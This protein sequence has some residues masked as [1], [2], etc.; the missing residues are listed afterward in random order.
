M[1]F[2]P[3]FL[4]SC[5][6]AAEKMLHESRHFLLAQFAEANRVREKDRDYAGSKTIFRSGSAGCRRARE[7]RL[8][9]VFSFGKI[10]NLR[11]VAPCAP[12]LHRARRASRS[13]ARDSIPHGHW[14]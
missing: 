5:A 3:N 4:L 13:I 10:D 14:N 2:S 1:I 8:L 9:F 6:I 11:R 12:I 7:T